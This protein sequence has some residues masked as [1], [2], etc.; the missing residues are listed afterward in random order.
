[1]EMA[2]KKQDAQNQPPVEV[3]PVLAPI[4]DTRVVRFT[5]HY[6]I[7]NSGESAEFD[8][9]E[10]QRLIDAG[11]AEPHGSVQAPTEPEKVPATVDELIAE[12]KA[13]GYSDEAAKRIAVERFEGKYGEEARYLDV[14]DVEYDDEDDLSVEEAMA[15][16][17]AKTDE[18][19]VE[20][21]KKYSLQFPEG[22]TKDSMIEAIVEAAQKKG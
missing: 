2:K 5:S 14:K 7:Y 11:V 16:L 12:V 13:A 15:Q 9:A 4:A 8:N 21:G 6:G 18:E 19:L 20:I 17:A 1:M 10:A 3:Q 22:V